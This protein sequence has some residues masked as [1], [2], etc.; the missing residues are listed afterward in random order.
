MTNKITSS[1]KVEATQEA[2]SSAQAKFKA[3]MARYREKGANEVTFKA[4]TEDPE[5]AAKEREL[6]W[7]EEEKI[8]KRQQR[9]D[10]KKEEGPPVRQMIGRRSGPG[11]G[12]SAVD[13][14]GEDETGRAATYTRKKAIGARSGKSGARTKPKRKP[15]TG[16]IYS[17]SEEELGGRYKTR[18]DEYDE[19]DDFVAPS[20]EEEIIQD[21]DEDEEPDAEGDEDEDEASAPPPPQRRSSSGVKRR[22]D[23]ASKGRA[24]ARDEEADAVGDPDPEVRGTG[25]TA[26]R[27]RIVDDD[28]EDD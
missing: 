12:L 26:K 5:R 28:D 22:R 16:E 7:K 13:L 25:R 18:E 15:R 24:G 6:A 21:D 1:I 17:D 23:S 14:E 4:T 9:L 11:V 10:E 2:G 3:S 27:R 8:K 19:E 20:S